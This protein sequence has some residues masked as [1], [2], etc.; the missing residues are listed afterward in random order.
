M[1]KQIVSFEKLHPVVQ[2]ITAMNI[3]GNVI[4]TEWLKYICHPGGSPDLLAA[5]ILADVVYW[6]RAQ[7]VRDE[8]TGGV[9]G[10]RERFAGEVLRYNYVVRAKHF[11]FTDRQVRDAVHRLEKMGL[12]TVDVRADYIGDQFV[13][14]LVF[15]TPVPEG[16]RK[17]TF[18][19]GTRLTLDGDPPPSQSLPPSPPDVSERGD[20]P[21]TNQEESNPP[22][23]GAV[24]SEPP[25]AEIPPPAPPTPDEVFAN[26]PRAV[27]A[28]AEKA[29]EPPSPDPLAPDTPGCALLFRWRSQSC[30]AKYGRD[31]TRLKK[32]RRFETVPQRDM[33]LAAEGDF[34][35]EEFTDL[36]A[37]AFN[38]CGNDLAG[39]VAYVHRA[40]DNRRNGNGKPGGSAAS[41]VDAGRFG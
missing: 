39:I 8:E 4:P 25:P 14:S 15:V 24:A 38:K 18:T 13:G 34:A 35:E 16:I 27:D 20:L 40:A 11:G 21:Q 30:A 32:T 17:I 41:T 19:A 36:L 12:V 31:E 33:F 9:R 37:G 3:T 7:Q 22:P 6:Y 5:W 23:T 10:Y 2:A 29:A 26:L 1:K 28:L